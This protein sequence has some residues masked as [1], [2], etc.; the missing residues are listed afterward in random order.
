MRTKA[1]SRPPVL[2]ATIASSSLGGRQMRRR[3]FVSLLGSAAALWPIRASAQVPVV[4]FVNSSSAQAQEAVAAAYRRGLEESG[5]V[6]GKSVL[7]ESRWANGQYNRLPELL[8]DLIERK[9][10]LIMAGGPPAAVAAI[11]GRRVDELWNE[12]A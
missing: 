2:I 6:E 5:F 7:I 3:E 9:V 11:G 8:G 1:P 10:A 12:P 4:G